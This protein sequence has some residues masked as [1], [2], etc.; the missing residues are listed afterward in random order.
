[1][2]WLP[3]ISQTLS[4]F[5]KMRVIA[6]YLHWS[7]DYCYFQ[8]FLLVFPSSWKPSNLYSKLGLS[9]VPSL[10]TSKIQTS[11]ILPIAVLCFTILLGSIHHLT[12]YIFYFLILCI[13]DLFLPEHKLHEGRDFAPFIPVLNPRAQNSA[14]HLLITNVAKQVHLKV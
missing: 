7:P 5:V 8:A 14:W 1:M 11:Q 13:V 10:A 3:I 4:S 6:I 12:Q 2:I 9:E